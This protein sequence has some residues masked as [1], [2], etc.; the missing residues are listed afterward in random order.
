MK[1]FIWH[2]RCMLAAKKASKFK[3][4]YHQYHWYRY[5]VICDIKNF[6]RRFRFWKKGNDIPF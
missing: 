6:F 4:Y 2:I 5:L 3:Y 1:E